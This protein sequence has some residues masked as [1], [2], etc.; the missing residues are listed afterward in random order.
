LFEI[1][2][3]FAKISA[4]SAFREATPKR[5]NYC[6]KILHLFAQTI[7]INTLGSEKLLML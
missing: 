3:A 4:N 1:W 2:G 6:A 7:I 5:Q